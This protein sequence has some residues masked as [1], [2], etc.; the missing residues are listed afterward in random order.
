M[1]LQQLNAIMTSLSLKKFIINVLN[2]VYLLS[3]CGCLKQHNVHVHVLLVFG[4]V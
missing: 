2:L 1:D 4:I 3:Q